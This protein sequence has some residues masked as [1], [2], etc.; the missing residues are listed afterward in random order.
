MRRRNRTSKPFWYKHLDGR[1]CDCDVDSFPIKKSA[2]K[3][4]YSDSL[5]RYM[6]V[7]CPNCGDTF[8]TTELLVEG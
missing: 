4:G 8:G 2:Q 5:V 1:D 6:K 3:T 7:E